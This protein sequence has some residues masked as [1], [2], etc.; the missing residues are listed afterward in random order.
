MRMNA[1][2][3]VQTGYCILTQKDT[4]VFESVNKQK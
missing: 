4:V 1:L 2:E 3:F